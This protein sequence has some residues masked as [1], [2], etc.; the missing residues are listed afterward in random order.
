MKQAHYSKSQIFVQKLNDKTH[1]FSQVFH[2]N[3]CW[4][5]FSRNQSCQQPRSPKPQHFHEFFTPQ[6]ST[7]FSGNQSWIFG[8]KTL[9]FRAKNS[10][11]VHIF[12]SAI[13]NVMTAPV[14]PTPNAAMASMIA[15]TALTSPTAEFACERSLGAFQRVKFNFDSLHDSFVH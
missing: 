12:Q 3:F 11:F 7:I 9:K 14:S 5:F 1:T 13:F 8:Q 4:Q 10:Y 2:P 15:A 6:K